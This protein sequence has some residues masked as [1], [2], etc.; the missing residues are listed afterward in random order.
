MLIATNVRCKYPVITKL[1]KAMHSTKGRGYPKSRFNPQ[2]TS[3]RKCQL[4]KFTKIIWRLCCRFSWLCLLI[5]WSQ[6]FFI[7]FFSFVFIQIDRL[8]VDW[9]NVW[10]STTVRLK[11]SALFFLRSTFNCSTASCLSRSIWA[12]CSSLF[13]RRPYS[14]SLCLF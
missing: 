2:S 3:C 7:F 11:K 6:T 14:S 13:H 10:F 12:S 5:G 9:N 4:T 1:M 8:S